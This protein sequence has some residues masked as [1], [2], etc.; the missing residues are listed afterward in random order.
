VNGCKAMKAWNL[1]VV[2]LPIISAEKTRGT[3]LPA[4]PSSS[5]SQSILLL[6]VSIGG[7]EPGGNACCSETLHLHHM[8]L[9]VQSSLLPSP[10]Q[11]H[12]PSRTPPPPPLS[13]AAVVSSLSSLDD[14]S[15]RSDL[16]CSKSKP[17]C[18]RRRTTPVRRARR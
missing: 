11:N 1:P 16:K 15:S 6:L 13:T 18:I 9:E 14:P 10:H 17:R 8:A 12:P 7:G 3:T 2:S 5:W 4:C